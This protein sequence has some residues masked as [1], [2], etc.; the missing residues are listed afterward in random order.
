[1]KNFLIVKMLLETTA[2]L[3]IPVQVYIGPEGSKRF[4]LQGFSD[5][6]DSWYSFLLE[7]ESTSGPYY[8]EKD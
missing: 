2:K 8:G 7:A 3:K 4:R 6:E 1:M 5:R